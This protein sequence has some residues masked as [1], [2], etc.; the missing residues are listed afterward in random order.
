VSDEQ[1]PFPPGLEDIVKS[2]SIVFPGWLIYLGRDNDGGGWPVLHFVSNTPDSY[3]PDEWIRVNHSF[4]VPMATYNERTWQSWIF[5]RYCDVWRHEAGESL[6]FN[7][8]RM[9]APHHA[10]G[11]NPYI[12]WYVG[13]YADTR[14]KA[15]DDK[16]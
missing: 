12:T 14:V 8:V 2:A 5:E 13:D 6:M 7:G 9:F 15:G 11:E 4:L 1:P 16:P 10:N 3:N